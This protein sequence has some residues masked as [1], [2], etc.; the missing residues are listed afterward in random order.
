MHFDSIVTFYHFNIGHWGIDMSK[1]ETIENTKVKSQLMEDKPVLHA[2]HP[3]PKTRREFLSYGLIGAAGYAFGPNINN[4]LNLSP[5]EVMAQECAHPLMCKTVPYMCFE[6]AGGMN[7]PGGNVIVGFGAGEDQEDFGSSQSLS[8]FVRMG[9]PSTMH[10][11]LSGMISPA[12]GLKFHS[13]SGLLRG[14]NSVLA[15]S[16]TNPTDLR[17]SVEGVFVCAISNDDT[18]SNPI[19][20]AHMARKAGA[21][22]DLVQILGTANSDT[23][24]RSTAP[25]SEIDLLYRPS[26]IRNFGDGESLISIGDEMMGNNYLNGSEPTF[27]A[28]RLKAF[29]DIVRKVGV[30]RF[31]EVASVESEIR[32]KNKVS[33]TLG[34]AKD[35]FNKY[36]PVDLNPAKNSDI[37]TLRTI[38]GTQQMDNSYVIGSKEEEVAAISN[39]VTK[40]IAGSGTVV[41]GGYDYHNGSAVTGQMKDYNLGRY[42]GM[43]IKLAAARGENMFIHLYTDGGV[44]GDSG[45]AIDNSP[46]G[47][48]RVN[49]VSDSGTRSGTL[50][51]VYKHNHNRVDYGESSNML[52]SGRKRQIGYF[53]QGGGV[54]AGATSM[55]NNVAQLWKSVI[56]NYLAT[57]V[58][59]N[60]DDEVV[61]V[62]GDVFESRF[63]ELPPDWQQLIRLRSLVA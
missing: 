34:G 16:E 61:R 51:L 32:A 40:G 52:L 28:G 45:G 15:Q 43:T 42:I 55:S 23:G 4:I 60:D 38:F 12:Y 5:M 6:A 26:T 37:N 33:S 21:R 53:V 63:G 10:P 19:N 25:Q 13:T 41:M 50:M 17:G 7:L 47:A 48:G 3:K 22:G 27:G 62:A 58:N 36:S 54:N 29:M 24:A 59:S 1:K 30:S 35:I 49:W 31:R 57:M 11:S 20:T 56:L 46:G 2:D 44:T 14:M 39:L 8:D 18:G 9:L